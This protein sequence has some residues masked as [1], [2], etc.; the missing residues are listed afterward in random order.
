MAGSA[1]DQQKLTYRKWLAPVAQKTPTVLPSV[2][3]ISARTASLLTARAPVACARAKG[4]ANAPIARCAR[5]NTRPA[6]TA[7]KNQL[8]TI[9][10]DTRI[11]DHAFSSYKSCNCNKE[12]KTGRRLCYSKIIL[13]SGD[14]KLP[15]IK[16]LV[17]VHLL[18]TVSAKQDARV[19]TAK[20]RSQKL[21]APAESALARTTASALTARPARRRSERFA[22]EKRVC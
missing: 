10:L 22:L 20:T 4:T 16:C 8:P 15:R 21:C 11:S 13:F 6:H 18:R 12:C 1:Q 5:Q 7:N 17:R 19:L 14:P 3:A 9:S 2:L